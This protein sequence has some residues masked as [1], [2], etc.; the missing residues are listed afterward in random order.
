MRL[1]QRCVQK[2]SNRIHIIGVCSARQRDVGA[3][4]PAGKPS[5]HGAFFNQ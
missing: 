3:A 5:S 4:N 1:Q 2:P